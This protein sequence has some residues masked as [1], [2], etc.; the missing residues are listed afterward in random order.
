MDLPK[1]TGQLAVSLNTRWSS[2]HPSGL[3]LYGQHIS[4]FKSSKCISV[5]SGCARS[6]LPHMGSSIFIAAWGI[7]S[8]STRDLGPWPE[9]EPGPPALRAQSLSHWTIEAV[10]KFMFKWFTSQRI[11]ESTLSYPVPLL[12]S[13]C[14]VSWMSCPKW[15]TEVQSVPCVFRR[16]NRMQILRLRRLRQT[17]ETACSHIP[18]HTHS[19]HQVWAHSK[20]EHVLGMN[21]PSLVLFSVFDQFCIIK[22][23]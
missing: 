1:L 17:V 10:P 22:S 23:P 16:W 8:C 11:Q 9:T 3:Q 12:T 14:S 13:N 18:A 4:S 19:R 21:T 7:F 15:L 2:Q 6:S 5:L 20:C